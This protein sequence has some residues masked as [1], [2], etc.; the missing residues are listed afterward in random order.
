MSPLPEHT[1]LCVNHG[2]S[3]MMSRSSSSNS[4]TTRSQGSMKSPSIPIGKTISKTPSEVQLCIDEAIADQRDYMFYC[5]LVKG[6]SLTQEMALDRTLRYENQACLAHVVRTR[7][8][9]PNTTTT[10][11]SEKSIIM[12][13]E[14][15]LHQQQPLW[16]HPYHQ[17]HMPY[18][19][20]DDWT[21]G[22]S[23]YCMEPSALSSLLGSLAAEALAIAGA[24]DDTIFDFEF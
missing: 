3:L 8:Q 4:P 16:L 22:L 6:I 23:D 21:P 18:Q 9:D 19:P 17:Y 12:D 2:E 24:E 15:Q 7:H 14:N 10:T 1:V 13:K 5:R 11:G 20:E